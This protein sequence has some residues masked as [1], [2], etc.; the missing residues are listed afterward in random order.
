MDAHYLKKVSFLGELSQK[1]LKLITKIAKKVHFDKGEQIF[2]A[3]TS[4]DRLF[5]VTN[6]R[7]KI[8]SCS[9]GGKIKVL[10]YLDQ[11]DFFGEMSLLDKEVRSAS[12]CAVEASNVITIHRNDFQKLLRNQPT[13]ALSFLKVLCN[14]LR[15]A[16]KE[17]E[18]LTFQNVLGRV[19]IILLDF[20][21]RYGKQ[22][23]EG[24]CLDIDFT[25]KEL[26]HLAGTAREMITR[27]ITRFKK[28]ECISF[29]TES[30]RITLTDMDKLKSFIY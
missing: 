28:T 12:A 9:P 29:N 6:G 22:T 19:A 20:A 7:I 27:I 21:G 16:D 24:L 30:R 2:S 15:R 1:N 17:I 18:A 23:P 3:S 4:G 5:I 11:G 14:R 26:A 8:F 13:L 25:H 10:D